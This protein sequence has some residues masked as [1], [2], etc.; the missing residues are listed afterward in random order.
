MIALAGLA[1]APYARDHVVAI[2]GAE[3]LTWGRFH[4]QV[5]GA[6]RK[7]AGCRRAVL[8]CQ[9][10]WRFAVALF[11]LLSAGAIAV[12]PPNS[13]PDTLARLP[14]GF[15]QVVDDRFESGVADWR[16]APDGDLAHLNLHTSGSSGETKC[17]TRSLRQLDVELAALGALWTLPEAPVLATVP[18][19]HAY[20]LI[21]KLLWPLVTGR[22]FVARSYDLWEDL[23]AD[24]P[25]Q[26]TVVTSP[27]HL[28]RLGGLPP[29]SPGRW[30]AM[31]LSAG[32]A[33]PEAAAM[34]ARD[35]FGVPVSEVY[36]S[37]ETGA[38]ATRVRDGGE[39]PWRALPGYAVSRSAEGQLHL[40]GA[41]ERVEIADRIEELPEGGFRLL[42]RADRIAKVE[43]KRIALDQ[44]ER[45]LSN[46][47]QVEDAAVVML[48]AQTVLAAVVVLSPA[49][50]AARAELGNFRFGRVLRRALLEVSEPAGIP[51]RWRFVEALPITAM[52]KRRATDLAALFGGPSDD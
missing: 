49:G 3:H 48:E 27:A 15:D 41:G 20:G 51:R 37:T 23:L 52:G 29:L 43:G 25:P 16:T 31:V 7:F 45:A 19:H 35:L 11:G 12:V 47:P 28:T 42:G 34:E 36:G 1:Q 33:L 14:G 26:A 46:L 32:A 8:L 9:D 10:G 5:G 6:A 17:V 22:P 18:H 13:R 4:E 38:I 50:L 40:D 21:F 44:V 30:P 39:P 24:L 2:R